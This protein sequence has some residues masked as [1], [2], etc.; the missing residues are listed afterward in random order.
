MPQTNIPVP[1]DHPLMVAWNNYCDTDEFKSA[2]EWAVRIK[3]EDG[4]PVD[5]IHREQHVKGAMW[6]CFTKGMESGYAAE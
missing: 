2:L 6:L 1:Y 3:Y 4:R 5:D